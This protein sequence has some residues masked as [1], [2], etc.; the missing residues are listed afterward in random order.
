MRE[1]L[2]WFVEM[3]IL[4]ESHVH[5]A[6]MT[7]K[8]ERAFHLSGFCEPKVRIDAELFRDGTFFFDWSD[9]F[10]LFY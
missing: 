8:R 4:S 7:S 6:Q 2:V 5:V 9:I 1:V 3:A 10:L